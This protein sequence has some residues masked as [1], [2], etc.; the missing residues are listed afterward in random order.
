MPTAPVAS[1]IHEDHLALALVASTVERVWNESDKP[2]D[3]L[4]SFEECKDFLKKSFSAPSG[5]SFPD[6]HIRKI[7]NDIDSNKDGKITKG[8][9]CKFIISL[10]NF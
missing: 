5:F 7:F 9:M 4:L 2:S 1:V 8:E 6:S 10:T 3:G